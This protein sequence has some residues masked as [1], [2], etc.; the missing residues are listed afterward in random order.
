MN[1]Y[2]HETH[3]PRQYMLKEA[4]GAMQSSS[5]TCLMK[6]P[7]A[8]RCMCKR[9]LVVLFTDNVQS[10]DTL[11]ISTRLSTSFLHLRDIHNIGPMVPRTQSCA[12]QVLVAW[13]L[14]FLYVHQ[15]VPLPTS[16]C[17]MA[18]GVTVI[19]YTTT[20][21]YDCTNLYSY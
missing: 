21:H 1:W 14:L 11:A 10:R 13:L 2:F 18:P 8:N 9:Y 16:L 5:N 15:C 17:D 20:L 3:A 12:G 4:Q 6:E 19:L 7:N